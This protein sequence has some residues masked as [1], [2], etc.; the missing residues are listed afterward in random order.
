VVCGMAVDPETAPHQLTHGG[1]AYA[2][3]SAHCLEKFRAAPDDYLGDRPPAEPVAPD[4]IFT[5]P[6][7]LEIEQVGS[8][9]A[10]SAAWRSS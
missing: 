4:A 6:M 3:C 1:K 2:F 5:C 10:R 9:T 7:H 8:V